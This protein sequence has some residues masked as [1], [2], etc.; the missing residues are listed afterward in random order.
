MTSFL[1]Y[2]VIPPLIHRMKN[3]T[4]I[5]TSKWSIGVIILIIGAAIVLSGAKKQSSL[6]RVYTVENRSVSQ[7]VQLSGDV[8][9]VDQLG[10]TFK[11]SGKIANLQ[12]KQGDKVE[13][14]TVLAELD[15]AS[16]NADL[17]QAQSA[18]ERAQANLA[19]VRAQNR[20]TDSNL[21]SVRTKLENTITEQ[22]TL[23]S[24]AYKELLN[25]NL[26]AYQ[27]DA[28]RNV[29]P[30]EVSGSYQSETTGT[31]AL[32]FYNSGADTGYSA[33]VTGLVNETIS[34]DVFGVPVA[35]GD[36]GLY[37]TLPASGDGQQYG[38]TDWTIP[39]PNDRSTTYQTKLSAYEKAKKT[40]IQSVTQ[41]ESD[42]NKLEAEQASGDADAVT[43]AQERQAIASVKEAQANVAKVLAQ[44]E[45][46]KII[47]PFDGTIA[48]L[49]YTI[50][51]T[52]SSGD[53]AG[54]TLV[55]GGNY[56]LS[57]SV[58]E[59]DVA[60]IKVG[61]KAN[62]TLDVYGDEVVW[63]GELTEIELVETEVDGVPVYTS[64]IK[65]I[66][67]DERIR[68]GMNARAS[69]LIAEKDNVLA[70]PASYLTKQG[71]TTTVLIKVNERE[72]EERTVATGL[73]GT[74]NFVEITEGLSEGAVI[75][76]P[77]VE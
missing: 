1:L 55:S 48:E 75:V 12:I 62:I 20:G 3:I 22:E 32:E 60:K 28:S 51:Q 61:D 37:V 10:L 26:Q 2:A 25:N 34:F 35:L 73:R 50:G 30:L 68:I 17:F 45:D 67:P 66:N 44:I 43:I 11:A 52:I 4:K 74:D 70:V 7:S 15:R 49:S 24:N 33:R 8:A 29:V 41:A 71:D 5:L 56:E 47:A 53:G 77:S 19:L 59:I 65:V 36:T 23:V 18:V 13:A 40:Q 39:V 9:A 16:L 42:L 27:I 6:E 21:E 63:E 38:S 76:M 69:I 31:I 46:T 64:I 57:M 72:R 54:V 14:G 58:P